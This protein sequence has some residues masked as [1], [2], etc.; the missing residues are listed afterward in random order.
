M[1]VVLA[2]DTYATI[3]EVV[4]RFRAQTIQDRLELILVVPAAEAHTVGAADL[5]GFAGTRVVSVDAVVPLAAARAAGVRVATAP[6]VFLGETHSYPDPRLAE[7]LVEAHDAPRTVVVPAFRNA[8]PEGALSWA[9]F[10]S[11]YGGWA[12]GLPAGEPAIVP[13]YNVAYRRSF[14][15]ALGD[16][17]PLA[18]AQSHELQADLRRN[19]GRAAF[20]PAARMDHA[21]ISRLRPWLHQRFVLGRVLAANRSRRWPKARRLAYACGAPLVPLVLLARRRDGLR[22]TR[23]REQVPA[24]AVPAMVLDTVIRATGELVG[25][26]LGAP[27]SFHDRLDEY[28]IHKIAYTGRSGASSSAAPAGPGS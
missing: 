2:T 5:D 25:Y 10:L 23:R 14:L 26:A 11:D 18:L 20:E 8:N 16:R 15:V 12:E 7:T 13:T 27:P 17:L 21:N 9:A 28:E 24:G 19:G 4:D 1:S 3:R 22:E 6:L